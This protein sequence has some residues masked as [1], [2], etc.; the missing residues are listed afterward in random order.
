MD[1]WKHRSKGMRCATCMFFVEK[2]V[3]RTVES[4]ADKT[5]GRCRRHAPTMQGWPV[6][7]A[8]DW[9]G[10]HK[11]NEN[12]AIG[13]R[14]L[15]CSRCGNKPSVHQWQ[16]CADN[17][18]YRPVCKECDIELNLLVLNWIGEPRANEIIEQY[19]QF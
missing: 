10:D 17:N 2:V 8:T 19:S 5:V 16:I 15:P 12:T 14:R 6:V 18:L 13:I 11:L 7:F 1:N 9:C 3:E 4:P